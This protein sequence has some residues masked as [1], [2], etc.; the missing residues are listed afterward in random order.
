MDKLFFVLQGETNEAMTLAKNISQQLDELYH[1]LEHAIHLLRYTS[2]YQRPATTVNGKV[3][4]A[5]RWL[6]QPD[7][8]L[9][10]FGRTMEFLL[11]MC[12]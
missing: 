9:F 5:Q 4:Q 1:S 7:L 10:G 2:D 8:D 3:D 12:E 11:V 6:S